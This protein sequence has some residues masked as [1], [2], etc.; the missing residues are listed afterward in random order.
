MLFGG[1]SRFAKQVPGEEKGV[2]V[3][4]NRAVF[5]GGSKRSIIPTRRRPK[6][7]SWLQATSL[8]P[9]L[10][11]PLDLEAWS[12]FTASFVEAFSTFG[13]R[14][15]TSFPG[16]T[17]SRRVCPSEAPTA[18][19][20]RASHPLTSKSDLL[21]HRDRPHG[22]RQVQEHWFEMDLLSLMGQLG[23]IPGTEQSEEAAPPRVGG[24]FIQSCR[25]RY[26]RMFSL[27][28]R[29]VVG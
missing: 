4:E 12:Q 25:T 17:W 13:S 2:E 14:W 23:A 9:G 21:E 28:L 19:S 1:K 3:D 15:R 26:S 27:G 18:A 11:G 6:W 10:Q 5:N 22:G 20:F 29:N 7:T 16:G 24:L 8:P